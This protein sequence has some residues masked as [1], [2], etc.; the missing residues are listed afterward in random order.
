MTTKYP[1]YPFP[2]YFLAKCLR[3]LKQDAWRDYAEE[4]IRI[5]EKTTNIPGHDPGHDDAL[6]ELRA[7]LKE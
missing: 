5:L 7:L 6:R 1:R 3:K 2:Y 4:A